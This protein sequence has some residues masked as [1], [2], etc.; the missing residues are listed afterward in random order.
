VGTQAAGVS[1]TAG[2]RPGHAHSGV[3]SSQ[4]EALIEAIAAI[5][6]TSAESA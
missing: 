5:E 6:L 4:L 3:P 1:S 2:R